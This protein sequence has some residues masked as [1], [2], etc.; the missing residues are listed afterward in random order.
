[1]VVEEGKEKQTLWYMPVQFLITSCESGFSHVNRI[2]IDT[3][4]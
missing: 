2:K 1:M 4:Q 3:T